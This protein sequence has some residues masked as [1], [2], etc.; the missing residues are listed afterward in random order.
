M[1]LAISNIAWNSALEPQVADRLAELGV[2]GVEIAPSKVHPTPLAATNSQLDRY[3]DFWAERG[4]EIVAMQALLFGQ[5]DL[6][7]FR[8]A[9]NRKAMRDYLAG[10]CRFAGRLGARS[11]VFGSPKNRL[12]GD[13]P[14]EEAQAIAIDFFRDLARVAASEGVWLCIEHNPTVYGADFVTTAGEALDLVRAVNQPG[15]GLHLDTGGFTLTGESLEPLA[16]A[17]EWWRHFHISEPNL[18]VIG[19]AEESDPA[20]LG[21]APSETAT[22]HTRY[23][24]AVRDSGYTGW[25]SLEMKTV[26]DEQCLDTVTRAVEFARACYEDGATPS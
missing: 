6:H 7:L 4:I 15:F 14:L 21:G 8:E 20:T 9:D 22:R 10:I 13:L 23:A 1:K 25:L 2:R 12:R 16:Q 5:N 17:G 3:R 11:L 26:P 19:R 18:A 24:A